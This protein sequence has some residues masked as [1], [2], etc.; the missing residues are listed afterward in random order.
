MTPAASL[1]AFTA[2]AAL[3]TVTPG[4]DTALVLRT[5]IGESRRAALAAAAGI[6]SGCLAWALL[7]AVGVAA[8]LAASET[9]YAVLRVVGAAWL[10]GL[11]LRLLWRSRAGGSPVAPA[12]DAPAAAPSGV[13]RAYARGLLTNLLNPKVGVFYVT[14]L[15]PFVP[16]GVDPGP[17]LVALGA[18]HATLGLAWFA[19]LVQTARAARR[20]LARPRV[21]A[22]IDR[23]AAVAFIGFGARLAFAQRGG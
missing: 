8:L 19:A 21:V 14:F 7:V 23:V 20:F 22:W 12:P 13:T 2:A 15:P 16:P 18:I 5:A 17:W 4:L 6:C 9:A 1:L 11:G 3:L 10:V